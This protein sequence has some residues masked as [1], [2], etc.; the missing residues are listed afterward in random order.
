M[1][2]DWEQ[3][4]S[5]PWNVLKMKVVVIL[6]LKKTMVTKQTAKITIPIQRIMKTRLTQQ[7]TKEIFIKMRHH[8]WIMKTLPQ[9]RMI[10]KKVIIVMK[11]RIAREA[12]QIPVDRLVLCP[13][14]RRLRDDGEGVD[15]RREL[16]LQ[17]R[18]DEPVPRE[19]LQRLKCSRDDD[20]LEVA[21]GA[22]AGAQRVTR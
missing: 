8:L 13:L 16:V 11:V 19:E 5:L 14:L 10:Q 22:C 4:N 9:N 7:V 17:D 20:D 15:V 2:M 6:L 3:K 12:I 21:L 1:K 18:V